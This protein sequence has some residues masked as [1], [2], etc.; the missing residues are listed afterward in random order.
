MAGTA[1]LA[2]LAVSLGAPVAGAQ[3]KPSG[4]MSQVT[5]LADFNGGGAL[6]GDNPAG[7]DFVVNSH[8]DV[9]YATTYGNQVYLTSAQTPTTNGIATL[10]GTPNGP[11]AVALDSQD[12]LYIAQMYAPWILKVPYV[13]GAYV[14]I[15]ASATS[16][17]SD[18]SPA[19]CTG[20][21]TTLC[22]IVSGLQSKTNGYGSIAVDA[23]GDL[24]VAEVY[25]TEGA[26][27]DHIWECNVACLYSKGS[28]TTIYTDSNYI[29]GMAV[30]PGGNLFFTDS[31]YSSAS[32]SETTSSNLYELPYTSGTGYAATATL[33]QT[34]T[35]EGTAIAQYNDQLST[36]ATDG[37]GT[38]YYAT[39]FD[40]VFA[41]PNNKGVV[42]TSNGYQ[43]TTQGAKILTVDAKG[44]VYVASYSSTFGSGGD[45]IGRVTL[46]SLSAS[47]AAVSK[48]SSP[49][50]ITVVD[51]LG[52]CTTTPAGP[53]ITFAAVEGG[54]AST[55]FAGAISGMCSGQGPS[56]S[57]GN[58]SELS[59]PLTG[60]NYSATLT[61]T[62]THVGERVAALTANDTTNKGSFTAAASG[63][64]QGPLVTLDPGVWTSYTTGFNDPYSVSVDAAGDL[65]IADQGAG[66]VFEIAAGTSTP[67]SIGTG[68]TKPY[69]T[70]FDANGNLFVADGGSDEIVEIPNVSGSLNTSDQTTVV[71]DTVL[72]GGTAL[73]GPSGLAF[74]PDGVLYISDLSNGR[75]V[76]WNPG[77]GFTA[78][79][80]TGLS[81]P[82]GVA[83]D[84]ASTLYVAETGG[85][86]VWVYPVGGPAV[87]MTPEGVTAPWGVAVDAS[88]SVLISD[89]ASGNI[90]RVPS[91]GGTLKPASALKIETNP[92]SAQGL[93]LDVSGNL[94]STDGSGAAVYA[95]NRLAGKL[96]FSTTDD[97]LTSTL[98]IWLENAGNLGMQLSAPK[99]SGLYFKLATASTGACG[100]SLAAGPV[101]AQGVEFDPAAGLGVGSTETG[102]VT[103][104]TNALN[105][106]SP[107]V[108]LSGTT[109]AA[110]KSQTITFANPFKNGTATYG[111]APTKLTATASSGLPVSFTVTGPATLLAGNML[112]ITGAGI[113]TVTANQPGN[114]TTYGPAPPKTIA[115]TV[116]KAVLTFKADSESTKY[117][118]PF[119]TP[120]AYTITG[121]VN[122]DGKRLL[123]G[124]PR[125]STTLSDKSAPGTYDGA[126]I[127]KNGTLVTL[128]NYRFRF[129][130]GNLTILPLGKSLKPVLSPAPDK[131]YTKAQTVTITDKT[132]GAVIYYTTNGKAPTIGPKDKYKAP[133]K[134]SSTTTVKAVAVAPGYTVSLPVSGTYTIK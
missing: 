74:G 50:T 124:E 106:P 33:L 45:T 29:G 36:V 65:A 133:F 55:E 12:N 38:V 13:N 69:A 104:E 100:V 80:V 48:S 51:N 58:G 54:A 27:S 24:F 116:D 103:L 131:T 112:K 6:S 91:V 130:D 109:A 39:E 88:G 63:V 114:D 122:G 72:F 2:A 1:I 82:W 70:A 10:M 132:K 108:S 30:D 37:N 14:P 25:G 31:V 62:P 64:G 128:A 67:V 17:Q 15:P 98:S 86:K 127:I 21:D 97:T 117:G 41:F 105:A 87:S 53:V 19:A 35:N 60:A 32:V 99:I 92:K 9:I 16:G 22:S 121:F 11:G 78:V 40:G 85:G 118:T 134:V 101:C 73:N 126:L 89:K 93:A 56:V 59:A 42:D 75:V 111:V 28:P 83:V 123:K 5:W 119:K 115:I 129:V 18:T 90:V 94:Y 61:F 52:A 47:A 95:V 125:L 4:I 49:A 110:P 20:N 84:A 66:K 81:F 8:G 102:T 113:V 34:L 107:T 43:V 76:S 3:S 46:N 71:A 79:R 44:N 57:G 120:F 96:T 26:T 77:N 7:S 23:A 68:F